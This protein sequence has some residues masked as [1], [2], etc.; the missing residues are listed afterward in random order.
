MAA[1]GSHRSVSILA[2]TTP[3]QL[4]QFREVTRKY[5][6]SAGQTGRARGCK[7][8]VWPLIG[9]IALW[10]ALHQAGRPLLLLPPLPLAA[11]TG[12]GSLHASCPSAP[13]TGMAG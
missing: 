5:L 4:T 3:E 2:V 10:R 1:Q 9:A 8:T 13:S 7:P 6:V 12:L 11:R